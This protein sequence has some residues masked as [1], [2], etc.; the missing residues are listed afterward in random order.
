MPPKPTPNTARGGSTGKVQRANVTNPLEQC[1]AKDNPDVLMGDGDDLQTLND[2]H[3]GNDELS[4][5]RARPHV[6]QEVA[7]END[8]AKK[9]FMDDPS[10]AMDDLRIQAGP[11]KKPEG[12]G[13]TSQLK[14][15]AGDDESAEEKGH[16]HP[17]KE[18]PADSCCIQCAMNYNIF[19]S[20]LLKPLKSK[21]IFSS[22]L[23]CGRSRPC[24]H[25]FQT[26]KQHECVEVDIQTRC[27]PQLYRVQVAA[28]AHEADP[29]ET[30]YETMNK[31][32]AILVKMIKSIRH[33]T[34]KAKDNNKDTIEAIYI[35]IAFE[36]DIYATNDLASLRE[37]PRLRN[38][39]NIH[40]TK[41]LPSIASLDF[42]RAAHLEI[43]AAHLVGKV[44]VKACR[45]CSKEEG[46][47]HECIVVPDKGKLTF[48]NGACTN[49]AITGH[50]CSLVEF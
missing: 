26:G 25:C 12:D 33:P 7:T 15:K 24:F 9:I 28:K 3:V 40:G 11:S 22:D 21:L 1:V 38:T 23:K 32:Q 47:F 50:S 43:I 17:R 13:S 30:T 16:K 48:F 35:R 14:R 4:N 46:F 8:Q 27:R 41:K 29:N 19:P 36:Q 42:T 18:G 45:H 10:P 34:S 49:C 2:P 31:T 39:L 20:V 44:A 5:P 6:H 37:M